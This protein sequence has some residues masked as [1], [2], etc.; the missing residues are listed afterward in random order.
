[1]FAS[2]DE[3]CERL[4]FQRGLMAR[5]M[6]VLLLLCKDRS[7]SYIEEILLISES[8]VRSRSKRIYAK[9][10]IHLKQEILDLIARG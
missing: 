8:T 7:K 6:E 5:E 9:L 1:M 2:I 10:D 4:G 3:G